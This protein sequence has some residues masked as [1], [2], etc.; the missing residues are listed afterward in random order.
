[1]PTPTPS[2]A[3]SLMDYFEDLEDPR[4]D[5]CKDHPLITCP[6]YCRLRGAQR[7]GGMEEH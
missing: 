6:L 5:R 1:M 3:A 7:R 2:C 4:I